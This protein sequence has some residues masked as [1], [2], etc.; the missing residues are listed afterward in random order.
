MK[1]SMMGWLAVIF[2]SQLLGTSWQTPF[3]EEPFEIAGKKVAVILGAGPAGLVAANTLFLAK[4][5][6]LILIVEKRPVFNRLNMVSFFPESWPMVKNLGLEAE[7]RSVATLTNRFGFYFDIGGISEEF[8][9]PKE[10]APDS[11]DFRGKIREIFKNPRVGLHVASLAA[12]QKQL[13]RTLSQNPQVRFIQGADVVSNEP[14][15]LGYHHVR[16]S[17]LDKTI[18]LR[19][20]LIIVAEGA[21][22]STRFR[23]G[24]EMQPMLKKQ[25]WCSGTIPL[26]DWHQN[27]PFIELIE[28]QKTGTPPLRVFGIFMNQAL[29]LNGQT[30]DEH[31]TVENCLVRNA[32]GLLKRVSKRDEKSLTEHLC[33]DDIGYSQELIHIVPSKADGFTSGKNLI[34]FGDAAGYGTPKGGI[35]FSMVLTA[36]PQALLDMLEQWSTL[37][38]QSIGRYGMRVSAIVDYWLGRIATDDTVL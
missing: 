8:S 11:F 17:F 33:V 4:K 19:P 29:F 13:A 12:I 7:I 26:R 1:F 14:D 10:V 18:G 31:E 37:R 2:C 28:K 27:E 15:T 34:L 25:L 6:D 38:E 35:G 24:I 32:L 22:S 36:Y 30:M 3:S 20:D 5:H 23:V 9:I 21:H 16:I